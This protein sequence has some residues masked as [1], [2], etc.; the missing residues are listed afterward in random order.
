MSS[1]KSRARSPAFASLPIRDKLI[2]TFI[3]VSVLSVSLVSLISYLTLRSNLQSSVEINLKAQAQSRASAIAG[4][5]AKQSEALESF[6]LSNEIQNQVLAAN[7]AY[8]TDDF[9]EIGDEL[10]QRD[11]AWKAA[12]D[13]EPLVQDVLNNAAADELHEF[14]DN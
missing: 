8:A 12:A 2:V 10:S 5:L 6:V 3:L 11:L 4:L 1:I 14:R 7:A 13:G 9:T